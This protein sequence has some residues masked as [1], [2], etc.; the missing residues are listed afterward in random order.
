MAKPATN[1]TDPPAVNKSQDAET[2]HAARDEILKILN[3]PSHKRTSQDVVKLMHHT[4]DAKFFKELTVKS[5]PAAHLACCQNMFYEFCQE[6]EYIFRYGEKGTKF[7]IIISGRI[8]VQIP[9]KNEQK[10]E[11]DFVEVIQLGDGAAFG[12]LALED[13]KPRAASIQCKIDTHFAV[14]DKADYKRILA[15]LVKEKRMDVVNFL[16][17]LPLF[18]TWTKGSLT[19]LSFF[20]KE[21]FFVRK[22]L[23]FKEK[24]ASDE[25]YI[26]RDGEFQFYKNIRLEPQAN[27]DF[28]LRK[29][30]NMLKKDHVHRT[31]L[32]ILSKG[33]IF[34]EDE[35]INDVPRNTSC[36]C[37]SMTASV[38]YLSKSDFLKRIKNDDSLKYIKEMLEI[39][40]NWVNNRLSYA[41]QL[42][43]YK[44]GATP[45]KSLKQSSYVPGPLQ[46][47]SIKHQRSYTTFKIIKSTSKSGCLSK[48]SDSNNY[49]ILYKQL[50]RE[51]KRKVDSV[52]PA[53][54]ETEGSSERVYT[55]RELKTSE[56]YKR[57]KTSKART[58]E[59]GM[60]RS[61]S[62]RRLGRESEYAL[63][64]ANKNLNAESPVPNRCKSSIDER[65][66]LKSG[67]TKSTT[68]SP[69]NT[70]QS[71]VSQIKARE[72]IVNSAISVFS[73]NAFPL[74]QGLWDAQRQSRSNNRGNHL[75]GQKQNYFSR[76]RNR[77]NVKIIS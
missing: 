16:Q 44:T 64:S 33:E 22:Q 42:E 24:D 55:A 36:I 23:V 26:I 34:G 40:S 39:K 11:A 76:T 4:K 5:S 9:I 45:R 3:T 63:D 72:Q 49:D 67:I 47:L 43:E 38:L 56:S 19:K 71:P 54:V 18:K 46:P 8:G 30:S 73:V 68:H 69:K 62:N 7:Y 60:T 70:A 17:T 32:A 12:E 29:V 6:G 53:R 21:K 2:L 35:V 65:P 31:D 77:F 66:R 61:K 57:I 28:V 52:S 13:N 48:A 50:D 20:F 75:L 59:I 51:F 10:D 74:Y 14:L 41:T 27:F 25:V 1:S 58:S 37:I 15:Q